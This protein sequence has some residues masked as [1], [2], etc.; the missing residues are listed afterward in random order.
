MNPEMGKKIAE[1]GAESLADIERFLRSGEAWLR[2]QHEEGLGGQEFCRQR[3]SLLDRVIQRLLKR[4]LSLRREKS[5][6]GISLLAVGGYGREELS[7][8]SDVDL[9]IL[10]PPG[11]GRDLE[12]DLQAILHPLW[13]WGLTVGHTV[14]TSKESLRAAQKDP[15]LF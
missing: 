11:K 9:L 6:P 7:P 2:R 5:R 14:Q 10:H 4:S 12:S 3:A 15:D 13:D 8:H 1:N